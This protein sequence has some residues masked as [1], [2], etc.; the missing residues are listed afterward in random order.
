MSINWAIIWPYLALLL[1]VLGLWAWERKR[2]EAVAKFEETV[3]AALLAI[4]TLV[5]FVQVI[6]RYGFNTGMQGALEFQRVAFAWLILFG[7]SYGIKI[8]SHLGVD[9]VIRLL[10]ATVFRGVALI[11]AIAVFLYA[12][13]LLNASWLNLFGADLSTNWRQTGAVGYWT[14]MF[15]RGTGLDELKWPEFLQPLTGQERVQRWVAYLMLPIGLA[16]LVFR[17]LQAIVAIWKGERE[18]VIA[19][20]EAE[21]LVAEHK[22]DLGDEMKA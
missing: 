6:L 10:P 5:A 9:A 1:I 13:I 15:E 21:D 17:S 20:H 8:G 14:F 12:A 19:G 11:G 4:I 18:L 2:P 16:L 3:V 7:M 22:D